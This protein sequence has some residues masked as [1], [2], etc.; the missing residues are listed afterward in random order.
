MNLASKCAFV[1]FLVS[2][3]GITAGCKVTP[4]DTTDVDGG[5]P[6]TKGNCV[7]FEATEEFN[8]TTRT[9]T[10]PWSTGKNVVITNGNG[11]LKIFSDNVDGE[12]RLDATPFT[13]DVHEAAN[14]AYGRLAARAD[15]AMATDASGT[16]SIRAEG[17]DFDG[18]RLNVHLPATGFDGATSAS[19][20]AGT[21]DYRAIPASTGNM[22]HTGAGDIDAVFGAASRVKVTGKTNLGIVVFRG[23]WTS[24]MVAMDQMGGSGQLGDGAGTLDATTGSGDIMFEL[25]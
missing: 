12:V 6:V 7:Q 13:R 15:P 18:W 11:D 10:Q 2:A 8:G 17:H 14:D 16:I 19:T 23:M 22:L 3:A 1:S 21:I 4:C 20:N 25:P 24:P 9:F 5:K